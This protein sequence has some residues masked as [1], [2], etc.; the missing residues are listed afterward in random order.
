MYREKDVKSIA[1]KMKMVYHLTGKSDNTKL[2]HYLTLIRPEAGDCVALTKNN[3]D[4]RTEIYIRKLLD[5]LKTGNSTKTPQ[6]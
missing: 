3:Y 5:P 1:N 2:R 4:K 6:Q